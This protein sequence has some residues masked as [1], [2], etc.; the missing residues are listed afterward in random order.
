MS[1][2]YTNRTRFTGPGGLVTRGVGQWASPSLIKSIQRNTITLSGVTSNTR[3]ITSVVPANS[4]LYWLGCTYSLDADPDTSSSAV[5]IDVTDAT[6]IT[7]FKNTGSNTAIVSFELVEYWP[8][9]L[10]SVQRDTIAFSGATSATKAI[11]AVNTAKAH[12]S[13]LG[14]T[15]N[16]V[17]GYWARFGPRI[18]LTSA[19]LVTCTKGIAADSITAGFQVAEYY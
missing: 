15:T 7:G 1:L 13:F 3:T 19:I 6:T 14:W 11:T 9:V 8:G 5:R 2:R 10:K 4:L 16:Q 12:A 18:D 17:N